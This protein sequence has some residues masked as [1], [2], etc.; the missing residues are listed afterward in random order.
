MAEL[1]KEVRAVTDPSTQSEKP[2]KRLQRD[3]P[4]VRRSRGLVLFAEYS[5]SFGSAIAFDLSN[6]SSS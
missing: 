4:S 6:P 1:P 5:R 3:T 2:Q